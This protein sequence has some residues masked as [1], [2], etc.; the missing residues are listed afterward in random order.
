MAAGY[1]AIYF[2]GVSA[3]RHDVE[4]N[5]FQQ[6]LT[7]KG[8][9]VHTHWHI[10]DIVK[11]TGGLPG[12]IAIAESRDSD[13][14]I[15]MTKAVAK[16]LSRE[17]VDCLKMRLINPQTVIVAPLIAIA[18]AMFAFV[19]IGLPIFSGPIARSI[20]AEFESQIATDSGGIFGFISTTCDISEEVITETEAMAKALKE[21]SN[22]PFPVD[23]TYIDAPFP[24][25][26]AMPG[27][28][29]MVTDDLIE[30]MEHPDE[31][32]GVLS[33]EM[34]HVSRR[35]VM[36]NLIRQMGFIVILEI[37]MGG[38][39]A[40]VELASAGIQFES[41]RH[42]RSTETEADEYAVRYLHEAGFNPYGLSM[43]FERLNEYESDADGETDSDASD[44]EEGYLQNLLMTHPDT[45]KRAKDTADLAAAYGTK[46]KNYASPLSD[47]AW[48]QL[49]EDCS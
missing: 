8:K 49:K 3:K 12:E 24:N 22:S 47:E 48:K 45:K 31:L 5:V 13:A 18:A 11:T 17:G 4:L 19:F 32:V 29:I 14:R 6:S 26:F 7:V 16:A 27:G 33:H 43:F 40:G 36:A 25:A 23:V 2:D 1:P 44:E 38:T 39:G 30:L 15:I 28:R 37:V 46:E 35:H 41:M 20:P 10:E 34:A 9:N 42:S 21:A